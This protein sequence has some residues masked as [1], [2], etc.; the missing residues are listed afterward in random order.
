MSSPYQPPEADSETEEGAA[1][2]EQDRGRVLLLV[3]VVVAV[4][5]VPL[6]LVYAPSPVIAYKAIPLL[7]ASFFLYQGRHWAKLLLLV[8]FGCVVLADLWLLTKS[9]DNPYASRLGIAYVVAHGVAH[10]AGLVMLSNSQAI[11]RFLRQQR[12][13]RSNRE[14]TAVSLDDDQDED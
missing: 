10:A 13:A 1:R 11:A 5:D 4:I 2:S 14:S 7:I 12:L 8:W 9:A 6:A 3:I